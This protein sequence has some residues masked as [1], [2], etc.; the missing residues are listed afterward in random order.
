MEN[1][2]SEQA[3]QAKELSKRYVKKAEQLKVQ[4]ELHNIRTALYA[5]LSETDKIPD[6]NEGLRF[7]TEGMEYISPNDIIDPWG[8]EYLFRVELAGQDAF[9]EDYNF[10]IYSA[11]P[12][13][14]P[15]NSDD[16]FLK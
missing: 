11:G 3:R 13:G 15:D 9:Q 14:I 12:D 6:N 5:Y 7:L 4:A 2:Q 10:Y 1:I 8:K 16:I